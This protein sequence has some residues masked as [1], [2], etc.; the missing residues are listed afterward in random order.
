[1]AAHELATDDDHHR[2]E[3][4]HD[5]EATPRRVDQPVQLTAGRLPI[6][7]RSP[8]PA[9]RDH[10]YASTSIKV[11]SIEPVSSPSSTTLPT[12]SERPVSPGSMRATGSPNSCGPFLKSTR[13]IALSIGAVP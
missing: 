9:K 13:G 3:Q 7:G 12:T 11:N 6:G 2:R 10:Q 1:V 5:R 8:P 4:E